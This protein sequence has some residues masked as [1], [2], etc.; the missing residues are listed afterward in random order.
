MLATRAEECFLLMPIGIDCWRRNGSDWRATAGNPESAF[1]SIVIICHH[2]FKRVQGDSVTFLRRGTHYSRMARNSVKRI[3]NFLEYLELVVW[4]IK[5][6]LMCKILK[7]DYIVMRRM[8]WLVWY[9][10]NEPNQIWIGCRISRRILALL[11]TY[12]C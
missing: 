9:L 1:I 10:L 6:K 5:F 11:K 7:R 12:F 3:V 8:A 4:H 2:K